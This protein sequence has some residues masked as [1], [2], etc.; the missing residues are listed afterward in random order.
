MGAQIDDVLVVARLMINYDLQTWT[1]M[2]R[3][4]MEM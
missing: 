3:T 4:G 1:Q 2:L